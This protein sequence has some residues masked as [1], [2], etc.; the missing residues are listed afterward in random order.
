MTWKFI[1]LNKESA[2]ISCEQN[3]WKYNVGMPESQA[4]VTWGLTDF[5]MPEIGICWVSFWTIVLVQ[6]QMIGYYSGASVVCVR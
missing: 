5:W 6:L 1:S 4:A 3:I 2:L